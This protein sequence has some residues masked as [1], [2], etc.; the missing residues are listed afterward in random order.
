MRSRLT[1]GS[2]QLHQINLLFLTIRFEDA[3]ESFCWFTWREGSDRGGTG[4]HK[5]NR[6]WYGEHGEYN[7]LVF[8]VEEVYA[9]SSNFMWQKM[10][11]VGMQSDWLGARQKKIM[12]VS[13]RGEL[14]D[15]S[16]SCLRYK[17][18]FSCWISC[19]FG[20][21]LNPE[22]HFSCLNALSEPVTFSLRS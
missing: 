22:R 11:M 4:N 3:L 9:E 18:F 8:I 2:D 21:L 20:R 6:W 15:V 16:T 13:V 14:Q 10:S 17:W 19:L 12:C 5:A 7:I 1:R